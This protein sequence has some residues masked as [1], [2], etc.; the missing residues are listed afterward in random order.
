MAFAS[1]QQDGQQGREGTRALMRRLNQG[2]RN[3]AGDQEIA[4]L[5][6]EIRAQQ[7]AD[8]TRRE[9]GLKALDAKIAY[10]TNPRLEAVLTVMGITSE[11]GGM[12]GRGGK[13]GQGGNAKGN[14]GK[15]NRPNAAA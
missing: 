12:G 7:Q 14:R 3:N 1:E 13:G 8:K 15:D 11:N 10:T 5:L 6:V 9:A 2:L 4:A